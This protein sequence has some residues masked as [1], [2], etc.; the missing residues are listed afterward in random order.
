MV[1]IGVLSSWFGHI[2][3][4][5]HVNPF[6]SDMQTCQ[7]RSQAK[8]E[9]NLC[10]AGFVGAKGPSAIWLCETATNKP[11]MPAVCE[12]I[13]IQVLK[14]KAKSEN[15]L[16]MRFHWRWTTEGSGESS[17]ENQEAFMTIFW[18]F[19]LL[20]E[21]PCIRG[22]PKEA[23]SEVSWIASALGCVWFL[24]SG[25]AMTRASTV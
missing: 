2:L 4:H 5:L 1:G 9:V 18:V 17:L 3:R 12:V 11:Q 23:R 22:V 21:T 7:E 20:E 16:A 13:A 19:F 25:I 24:N 14:Q 15:L 8:A 10:L 6:D